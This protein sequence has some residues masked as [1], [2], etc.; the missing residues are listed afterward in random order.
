MIIIIIIIIIIVITQHLIKPVLS[1]VRDVYGSCF[2]SQ[3]QMG[4]PK[5]WNML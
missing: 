2:R 1:R 3:E 5:F 4:V